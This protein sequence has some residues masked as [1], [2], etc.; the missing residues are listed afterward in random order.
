MAEGRETQGSGQRGCE[1]GVGTAA[2]S[3]DVP[4]RSQLTFIT[5]LPYCAG[6]AFV[7]ENSV[8]GRRLALQH[9]CRA[10]SAGGRLPQ[11]G[12]VPSAES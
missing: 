4:D 5:F 11:G 3:A 10:L 12:R 6:S 8:R 9:V 7:G 2:G 1:R